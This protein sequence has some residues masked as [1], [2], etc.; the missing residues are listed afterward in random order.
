MRSQFDGCLWS[1]FSTTSKSPKTPSCVFICIFLVF[2]PYLTYQLDEIDP[3]QQ[4]GILPLKYNTQKI[5]IETSLLESV[6]ES[7]KLVEGSQHTEHH[8]LLPVSCPTNSQARTFS[9]TTT[10]RCLRSPTT[11]SST[12]ILPSSVFL[13][14]KT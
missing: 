7:I 8:K 6:A 11:K 14:R 10:K 9:S 12:I 3:P 4:V 13:Q 2:L 5:S 1:R